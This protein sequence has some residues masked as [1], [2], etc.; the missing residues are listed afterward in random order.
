MKNLLSILFLALFCGCATAAPILQQRYTTNVAS[1]VD[2]IVTNAAN[3]AGSNA[4]ANLIGFSQGNT[5]GGSA[6]FLIGSGGNSTISGS[7]NVAIGLQ[8]LN[9]DTSGSFNTAIGV[10]SLNVNLTGGQNTSVGYGALQS[11]TTATLSDAFGLHALS[12]NTNGVGNVGI[13]SS[14]LGNNLGGS[15]N[16]AIG[17]QAGKNSL[18]SSNVYIANIGVSTDTNLIRIGDNQSDFFLAGTVHVG[19][20]I[21]NG[22][23]VTNTPKIFTVTNTTPTDTTSLAQALIWLVVTNNGTAYRVPAF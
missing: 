16:T 13:G 12:S 19:V 17:Y 5:N 21:A 2:G 1:V 9:Q 15:F 11:S 14:A 20:L 10:F 22:A 3:S 23:S 18:G 4:A 8:S 7:D 6:N